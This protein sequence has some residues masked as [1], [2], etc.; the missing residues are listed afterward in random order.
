MLFDQIRIEAI[1][2]GGNRRVSGEDHF[3]RHARHR[4]FKADA[5]FLHAAADRFQ[6]R[7]SAVP[8]VQVKNARR[9][10]HG[11]ERAETADAQQ[12]LLPDSRARVSAVEAGVSSR[13]SGEH[14]LPHPNREG[15]RSQRPTATR[16][17]LA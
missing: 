16:Q 11:F 2:A 1:M 10:A 15:T 12:Q 5:L 13:S 3:P 4:A 17:T 8:F 7:K 6:H 14:S 9:D